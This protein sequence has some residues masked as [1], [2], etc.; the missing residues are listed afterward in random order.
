MM[1]NKR[2]KRNRIL[3][4]LLFTLLLS[5]MISLTVLSGFFYRSVQEN[6]IDRYR[7]ETT[8][9]MSVFSKNIDYYISTFVDSAKSVYS[10]SN[11]MNLFSSR[12]SHLVTQAERDMI[13]E[14]L[15]TVYYSCTTSRQIYLA[16]SRLGQSYLYYPS[17]ISMS[18][19]ALHSGTQLPEFESFMEVYIEST[20]E[21]DTYEHLLKFSKNESSVQVITVWVPIYDLPRNTGIIA[22]LAIDIPIDFFLNNS[23]LTLAENETIYIVDEQGS[24]LVSSD[25]SMI[26]ESMDSVIESVRMPDSWMERICCSDYEMI[27]SCDIDLDYCQWK[28]YKTIPFANIYD[29]TWELMMTY[30][31]TFALLLLLILI[32]NSIQI[33]HLISPIKKMN[34]YMGQIVRQPEMGGGE[35]LR[36]RVAYKSRDEISDMIETFDH[37]VLT[38]KNYKIQKYEIE[39]AYNKS[40]FKMLQAQINPHFIYNTLQYFATS[41]LKKKDMEQYRL[42][43]SFGQMMHY[44]MVL[45]PHMVPLGQELEYVERYVN[46]QRMRFETQEQ[47]DYQIMDEAKNVLVPKMCLQPL[48][49][50]SITHGRVFREPNKHMAILA[51]YDGKWLHLQVKDDGVSICEEKKALIAAKLDRVR[52]RMI[53]HDLTMGEEEYYMEASLGLDADARQHFIGIENVYYRLMLLFSDVSMTVEPNDWNGTTVKI[54]ILLE[55]RHQGKG[56]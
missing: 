50:N 10:N 2:T 51:E 17:N 49:E 54:D 33:A 39:L 40:T 37:M 38:L 14:Y 4:K 25:S 29:T 21:I 46:L 36:Q 42:L 11:L 53:H 5:V 32:I 41:A 24:I 9:A 52:A 1:K 30:L 34:D 18:Y 23:Q 16:C 27:I 13:F 47:I 6:A 8:T 22:R 12:Q 56:E 45:N 3:S 48:V 20:H 26:G 43:T 55:K 7:M 35:T 28:M 31:M 19:R 15:R 44:A